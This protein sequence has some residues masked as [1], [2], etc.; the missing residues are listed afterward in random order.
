[1]KIIK[2]E[3][4]DSNIGQ[5]EESSKDGSEVSGISAQD[6]QSPSPVLCEEARVPDNVLIATCADIP[7]VISSTSKTS[8]N[9]SSKAT[10]VRLL[11]CL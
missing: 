1:M 5:N 10:K 7:N 2:N 3:D 9:K 6:V 8:D 4:T 11:I